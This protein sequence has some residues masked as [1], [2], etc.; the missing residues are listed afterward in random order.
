METFR[1]SKLRL[2]FPVSEYYSCEYRPFFPLPL[3]TI[4]R[5]LPSLFSRE[6]VSRT[7]L[8]PLFCIHFLLWT[9][10][11]YPEFCYSFW[12]PTLFPEIWSC[13]YSETCRM[14][15]WKSAVDTPEI[16]CGC[17]WRHVFFPLPRGHYGH[18]SKMWCEH[19]E[20]HCEGIPQV[21]AGTPPPLPKH[22]VETSVPSF[23]PL[24]NKLQ[25]PV[26]NVRKPSKTRCRLLWKIVARLPKHVS[27]TRE[28]LCRNSVHASELLKYPA[29][30]S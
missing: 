12:Y 1:K 14:Q 21:G 5:H 22:V 28:T 27:G 8:K 19:S 20:I 24:P 4:F 18:Y 30:T 15:P 26:K 16:W 25:D 29:G 11:K 9:Y 23:L 6:F 2:W 17:P 3:S 13:Y 10:W 7:P